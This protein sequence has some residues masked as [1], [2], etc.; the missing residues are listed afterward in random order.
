MNLVYV[1]QSGNTGLNLRDSQQPVFILA[2]MT[3]PERAWFTP[4]KDFFRVAKE[5]FENELS[6]PFEIHAA[7]LKCG[8]GLFKGLPLERRLSFR[9]DLLNLLADS[10]VTVV[11][12]R[13]IKAKVEAFCMENYGPGIK[14]NPYVMAL[15]FVCMEVDHYLRQKGP[16]QVGTLI[17]DEQKENLD[18]VERSLR[19][20]AEQ[21]ILPRMAAIFWLLC[22]GSSWPVERHR[23][24]GRVLCI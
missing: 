17:F 14:V 2:A 24:A 3:V 21:G 11:Y 18:V 6:Y 5:L 20:L 16:D 12:R 8:R 9:D 10:G 7:D 22:L 19:N 23:P 4:E 13:I 15:P 1:D